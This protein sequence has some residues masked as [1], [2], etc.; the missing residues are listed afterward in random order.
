VNGKDILMIMFMVSNHMKEDDQIK[1]DLWK[2]DENEW[3]TIP[4]IDEWI[5]EVERRTGWDI[6]PECESI[7]EQLKKS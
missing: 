5:D 6:R 3:D 7:R 2:I 1:T 4:E